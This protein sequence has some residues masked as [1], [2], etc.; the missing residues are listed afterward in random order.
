MRHDTVL[1]VG[2]RVRVKDG[3]GWSGLIGVVVGHLPGD[4]TLYNVSPFT[5]H[6][7]EFETDRPVISKTAPFSPWEI[8][9]AED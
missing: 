8:E 1:P 5:D 9:R 4:H 6:I 3:N 7:V 2:T